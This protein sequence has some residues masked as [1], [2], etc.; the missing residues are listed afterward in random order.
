MYLTETIEYWN[1]GYF[2]VQYFATPEWENDGIGSYEYWGMKGYDAGQ[3]YPV[4]NDFPEWDKSIYTESENWLIAI[5]L[6][7]NLQRIEERFFSM[8]REE[9]I[10]DN[11]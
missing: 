2:D 4:L 3:D 6:I 1:D 5:H 7:T 11:Y 8:L 10:P 9:T